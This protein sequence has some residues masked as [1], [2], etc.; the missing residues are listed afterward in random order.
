MEGAV[1][2][3]LPVPAAAAVSAVAAVQ[4]LVQRPLRVLLQVPLLHRRRRQLR[5]V[6]VAGGQ[7]VVGPGEGGGQAVTVQCGYPLVG[8]GSAVGGLVTQAAAVLQVGCSP[9]VPATEL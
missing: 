1:M 7:V 8:E 3:S 9:R 6:A 4:R 5:Q 2:S